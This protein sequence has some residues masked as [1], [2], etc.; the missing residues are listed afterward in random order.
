MP[1]RIDPCLVRAETI[2]P[3]RAVSLFNALEERY[4][5]FAIHLPSPLDGLAR[6][7]AAFL[8][9][10]GNEP[11]EEIAGLNPVLVG[12]PWLFWDLF[13]ELEDEILLGIAE[14]G[15]CH[16]LAS[17]I[18]DH[19]VDGQFPLPE[20]VTL[21]HQ[22]LYAAAWQRYRILFP[23][24]SP[25][26]GHFD[27]LAAEHL[28][29][30]SLEVATQTDARLLTAENFPTMPYGKVAP[31]VTTIAALSEA[32][33]Q[34]ALLPFIED[35][36][37]H[38]AVASQL[39]DDVGDWR[40]DLAGRHLTHFLTGL[41][42]P[43]TWEAEPWPTAE[44]LQANIDAEWLDIDALTNVKQSLDLAIAAVKEVDCPAWVE[45]VHGYWERADGHQSRFVAR[46][47]YQALQPVWAGEAGQETSP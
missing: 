36:L 32:S 15:M 10:A 1:D 13:H 40:D 25:F 46:H 24:S 17:V 7:R 5:S 8:G 3:G 18:L 6:R 29:G 47:L 44:T 21:F 41:A 14:A 20:A 19:S 12:T 22:A 2:T 9:A 43:E 26:W 33:G 38:I 11:F 35:S 31:I 16:V 34:P 45:Y 37:K 28:Q 30:L 27:R 4:R 39:L 23:S 42:P